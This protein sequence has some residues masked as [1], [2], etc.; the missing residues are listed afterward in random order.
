MATRGLSGIA[1]GV[2]GCDISYM[3][4]SVFACIYTIHGPCSTS[5]LGIAFTIVTIHHTSCCLHF[6]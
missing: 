6:V 4:V 5:S 3:S 2:V 1:V